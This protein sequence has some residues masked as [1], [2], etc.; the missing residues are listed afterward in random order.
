MNIANKRDFFSG[1]IIIVFV[2]YGFFLLRGIPT[3]AAIFPQ[4]MLAGMGVLAIILS[5][6][7]VNWKIKVKD[8]NNGKKLSSKSVPRVEGKLLIFLCMLVVGLYV[9]LMPVLG[10][11]ISTALFIFTILFL[12]GMKRYFL[13]LI[14]SLLTAIVVF[15]LF[16]TIMYISLPSGIF[17][18]TEFVYQTFN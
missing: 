4:F 12:Q 3:K 17:D 14:I 1:V 13:M 9:L 5:I 10:F 2:A 8:D 18:P 11:L 6:S 7:S 15:L 16:R